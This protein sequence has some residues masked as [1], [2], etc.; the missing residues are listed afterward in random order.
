MLVGTPLNKLEPEHPGKNS[1]SHLGS[2]KQSWM[3]PAGLIPSGYKSG[4]NG[5]DTTAILYN[6]DYILVV[7]EPADSF[8]PKKY[9]K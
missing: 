4:Q 3:N 6:S 8:I 2:S 1:E 7:G 9:L 5:D